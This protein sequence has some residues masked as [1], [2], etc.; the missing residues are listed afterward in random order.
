MTESDCSRHSMDR[1]IPA[2]RIL[3]V[4]PYRRA[5]QQP[6]TRLRSPEAR[7]VSSQLAGVYAEL[8]ALARDL[9]RFRLLPTGTLE[10]EHKPM[11]SVGLFGLGGVAWGRGAGRATDG[12]N[13]VH[14]C[15]RFAVRC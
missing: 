5:Q 1:S 11:C 10:A 4:P 13:A 8:A 12:L 3:R 9:P 2:D 14:L 7:R 6:T 15:P